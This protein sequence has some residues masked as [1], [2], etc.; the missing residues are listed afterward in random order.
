MPIREKNDPYSA[1]Q[2]PLVPADAPGNLALPPPA[3]MPQPA[4]TRQAAQQAPPEQPSTLHPELELVLLAG[5]ARP[6]EPVTQGISSAPNRIS[7]KL[8]ALAATSN[9]PDI[10]A[11]YMRAKQLGL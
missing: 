3:P 10:I 9:S 1:S 6:T 2:N 7:Q 4:P 8:S 5:T 11:L